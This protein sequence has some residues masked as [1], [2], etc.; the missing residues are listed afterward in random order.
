MRF[1]RLVLVSAAILIGMFVNEIDAQ[2]VPSPTVTANLSLKNGK[3]SF[4]SGEEIEL[5]ISV[6]TSE[7]GCFVVSD[8]QPSPMDK[9]ELTPTDGAYR[10]V[11]GDWRGSDGFSWMQMEANKPAIIRIVL[12]DSYRFDE[13]GTYAVKVRTGHVSCGVFS[14]AEPT[15][16]TTNPVTFNVEPFEATEEKQL[17]EELERRVRASTNE[18]QADRL[19]RQLDYLPGD[20]ATRAKLSL[21]LNEKTFYPFGVHVDEGLWIARNR[22]MVVSAL[23]LAVADP[24]LPVGAGWLSTLVELKRNTIK[25]QQPCCHM[26]Q[27]SEP[28]TLMAQYVHQLALS[29][30]Q[31]TGEPLIIAAT[32]VFEADAAGLTPE[33][34]ADFQLAREIIVTHFSEINEY[35]VDSILRQFGKYLEDRR[36][37][38]PLQNL[39][40][41]SE[42]IFSSN[43]AEALKQM[44][45]ITPDGLDR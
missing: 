35:S 13:R 36:M 41:H 1:P 18:R 34:Q 9:I 33:Q 2:P 30:P 39:I 38:L 17:A 10:W 26:V 25:P 44:Q 16:L 20:D 42:G 15:E 14:K 40:D 4:R 23:E 7:P 8:T 6:R 11:Q 31:R 5:E 43:R 19:A 12:N 32:S 37:I 28:D 29:L 3:S 22:A 21:F 27:R 24:T 45:K